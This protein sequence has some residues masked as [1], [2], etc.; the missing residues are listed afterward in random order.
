LDAFRDAKLKDS[1]GLRAG[2]ADAYR[3]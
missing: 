1:S 2:A 3:L